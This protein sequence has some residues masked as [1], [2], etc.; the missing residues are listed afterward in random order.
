MKTLIKILCLSVL[1]FSCDDI[2]DCIGEYDDCGVCNGNNSNKDECGICN[3]E[4]DCTPFID[5]INGSYDCTGN[6]QDACPL[7]NLDCPIVNP[8]GMIVDYF[9]I[10]QF[11]GPHAIIIEDLE[12]YRIELTIWPDTW[13]IANDP[14]YSDLLEP[15][16]NRY[17][18]QVLGNVFEYNG[19]K[20]I[21]VCNP[22]DLD[23]LD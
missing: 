14:E 6:S 20:Q 3:G 17:F 18:I 21:L 13:D 22:D 8:S 1:W 12:G 9:D 2:D 7:G 4:G 16:Y 19:E 11:G 23:I 5:I 15:P 10:T